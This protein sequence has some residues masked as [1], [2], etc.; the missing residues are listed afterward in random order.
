M[1]QHVLSTGRINN[2]T[3]RFL[4][5][6]LILS[7]IISCSVPGMANKESYERNHTVYAVDFNPQ[8]LNKIYIYKMEEGDWISIGEVKNG[9]NA[10]YSIN[11]V[12]DHLTVTAN[13]AP[14]EVPNY[15]TWLK[16]AIEE[17]GYSSSSTYD[18]FETVEE[19]WI[20][21]IDLKKFPLIE[22]EQEHRMLM[23]EIK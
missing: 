11:I 5:I 16:Y 20:Y 9:L 17:L 23:Y 21:T 15:K 1:S 6:L 19:G 3:S 14:M 4:F 18:V 12:D 2:Y 13:Q 22:Q 8:N 10:K 7:T